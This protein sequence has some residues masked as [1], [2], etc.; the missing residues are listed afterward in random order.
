MRA[1]QKVDTKPA[2]HTINF[3]TL[4][5]FIPFKVM[6]LKLN[7]TISDLAVVVININ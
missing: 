2:T 4:L 6:S 1:Y 7:S 5:E 3:Y